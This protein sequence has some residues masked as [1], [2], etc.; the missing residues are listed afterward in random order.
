MAGFSHRELSFFRHH[1]F[2]PPGLPQ[3]DDQTPVL[4]KSLVKLVSEALGDFGRLISEEEQP[5][6]RHVAE[7]IGK[8][9]Q[10]RD[11]TDGVVSEKELLEALKEMSQA[12]GGKYLHAQMV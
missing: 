11:T 7:A 3:K 9:D 10:T 1:L 6:V 2:L 12:N 4:D 5:L 8:L